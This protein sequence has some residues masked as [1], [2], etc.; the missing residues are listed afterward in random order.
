MNEFNTDASRTQIRGPGS[1]SQSTQPATPAVARSAVGKAAP[2][3]GN[4]VPPTAPSAPAEQAG[5]AVDS[6]VSVLNEYVQSQQRDL[7]FS[8]DSASGRS[9]VR[10]LDG[11]TKEV[12]RQIPSDVALRLARNV[13]D[14]MEE[15]Q[16]AES[17]P[18]TGAYGAPGNGTDLQLINTKV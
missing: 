2:Q 1:N 16:S 10:V 14:V 5:A 17:Q 12:I 9:V 4:G 15:M 13:K 11:S 8:T 3:S 7:Q 6:A 18:S